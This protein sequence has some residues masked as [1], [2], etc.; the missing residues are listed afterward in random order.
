MLCWQDSI[1]F[2]DNMAPGFAT[3]LLQTTL[4]NGKELLEGVKKGGGYLGWA[5]GKIEVLVVRVLD[6]V[7]GKAAITV[8]D[9]LAKLADRTVDGTL[10][11][12]FVKRGGKIFTD[13][14]RNRVLPVTTTL[15]A[16]PAQVRT[17]AVAAK[18][19]MVAITGVD[20]LVGSLDAAL[21]RFRLTAAL[22]NTL[23]ATY[24]Q[25]RGQVGWGLTGLSPGGLIWGL[26]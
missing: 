19:K 22:R 7:I 6:S 2:A 23:V 1:Q 13:A 25:L 9:R 4:A 3:D 12:A 24:K 8:V 16:A 26:I 21:L 11:S 10:N 18:D 15:T 14:Y 5:V 20:K 17:S